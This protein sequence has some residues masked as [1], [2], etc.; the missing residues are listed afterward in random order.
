VFVEETASPVAN[1]KQP[2]Q[3]GL[4]REVVLPG[5]NSNE[6]SVTL[7]IR[8]RLGETEEIFQLPLTQEMISRLMFEAQ[9]REINVAE[10][11]AELITAKLKTD[12]GQSV[13]NGERKAPPPGA[14]PG[15]GF[16]E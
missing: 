2:S 13:P 10:L 12:F 5:I 8:M 15:R 4:T 16:S 14:K 11:L 9:V 1:S 7:A 6:P 3:Q